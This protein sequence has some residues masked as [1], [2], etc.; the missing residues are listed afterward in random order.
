MFIPASL[1]S[2][3]VAALLATA[4]AAHAAS[5]AV[6]CGY[7]A[8]TGEMRVGPVG[9]AAIYMKF[10]DDGPIE[11]N[12][13]VC[14]DQAVLGSLDRVIFAGGP[15]LQLTLD[16]RGGSFGPGRDPDPTGISE[17]KFRFQSSI[18]HVA[19]TVWASRGN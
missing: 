3:L 17:V 2:V 15:S 11:V 13:D 18:Q 5:G 16:G 19:L 10:D 1:A 6:P 4:P 9:T 12:G 7:D 14:S 8:A